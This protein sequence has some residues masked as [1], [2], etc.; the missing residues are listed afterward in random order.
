MERSGCAYL[1]PSPLL[2]SAYRTVR[3]SAH[4]QSINLKA[5]PDTNISNSVTKHMGLTYKYLMELLEMEPI[6]NT[7]CIG[8]GP[9][10]R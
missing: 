5:K 2:T 9:E 6:N 8:Q 1:E 4:Y 7:T 3:Y 10:T